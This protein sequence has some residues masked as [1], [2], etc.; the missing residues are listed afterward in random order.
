MSTA[1]RLPSV[2]GDFVLAWGDGADAFIERVQAQ[3]Y[4][5][6]TEP[7]EPA[8][9]ALR[10][11]ARKGRAADGTQWIAVADLVGGELDAGAM[12]AIGK[13]RVPPQR[14]WR[15]RFAQV[16]WSAQAKRVVALSDHFSTL[17]LYVMVHDG[18]FV[19]GTDFRVVSSAPWC[20]RT[21]DL[22]AIYHYFNFAHIPAPKSLFTDVERLPPATRFAWEHGRV[23]EERFWIPEYPEDLRGSEEALA[24]EMQ[25]RMIASVNDYRPPEAQPWG[26]FLSGGTDSSSITSI[27]SRRG[28]VKSFSI[29]FAEERYDE[30]GYARLA[31]KACGADPTFHSV[32]QKEAQALVPRV[33]EA[34]DQPFGGTSSVPTLAC[35]DLAEGAGMKL[36][37][38]GDGGDEIFGGNERYAKDRIMETWFA[39][40]EPLKAVGRAVGGVAGRSGN[41]F[42][43]RVE[44]F[45]ERSSLPNPDR[46]YTDDSFASDHYEAMLTPE[47]RAA[48]P[49]DASLEWMRSVYRLGSTGGPLHRVMRLDLSNAIAQHDLRKVD[50][51]TRARGISVRFP[52][53]DPKLV[54]WVNRLPEHYKV[55]GLQK[56]Y[57]FKKATKGILPD[58]ILKKK[59]QGF[60]LPI[61]VWMRSDPPFQAMMRETL[62]ATR[63]RQRGFW[64]P[65]FV[66]GLIAEHAS[67]SW[68]HSDYLFRLLMLE[69]WLRRY[70]DAS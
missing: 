31:A 4:T 15:G 61:S 38:A 53:L 47:F 62:F 24:R 16:A 3:G 35:A 28:R 5:R 67:G 33:V 34:Y 60:G 7:G 29:G 17:S 26:C 46:F 70:V 59:K 27:L 10:G 68:D 57:L 37:V 9:A 18:V 50:S 13:E 22:E 64:R 36:L 20:K 6:V 65:A 41:F 58:E 40:P 8:Q 23:V 49:R 19:A 42:L 32:S 56:R 52:Y 11:D 21:L 1:D 54:E 51:A 30:L 63:T 25:E 48:V 45:F 69:L 14:E 44:N 66:E 2:L 55:R 12:G 39:M 43:N